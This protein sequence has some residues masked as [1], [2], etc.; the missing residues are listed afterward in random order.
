MAK[1]TIETLF[2][3]IARINQL[4]FE[5]MADIRISILFEDLSIKL[6]LKVLLYIFEYHLCGL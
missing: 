1:I 5:S 3:D 2:E 4:M 6:C